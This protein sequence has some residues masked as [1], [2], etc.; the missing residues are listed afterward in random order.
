[1]A[2]GIRFLNWARARAL[3]CDTGYPGRHLRGLHC[4]EETKWSERGDRQRR[5]IIL[6]TLVTSTTILVIA[7]AQH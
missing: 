7:V 5:L 6:L 4:N 3:R 2:E 1:M